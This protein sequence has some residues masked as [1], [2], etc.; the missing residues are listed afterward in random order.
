M[1]CHVIA[2]GDDGSDLDS[3]EKQT[4]RSLTQGLAE[5]PIM[6]P[7]QG[8]AVKILDVGETAFAIEAM[9]LPQRTLRDAK[10]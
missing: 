9:F 3:L 2:A 8:A 1:T 7:P 4:I 6:A 10:E 5:R